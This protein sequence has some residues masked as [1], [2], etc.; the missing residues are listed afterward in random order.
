MQI[1]KKLK[2]AVS[3]SMLGVVI[4]VSACNEQ[5]K[6][7]HGEISMDTTAGQD[8]LIIDTTASVSYGTVG[9]APTHSPDLDTLTY[10]DKGVKPEEAFKEKNEK[11]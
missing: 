5:P 10:I 1:L 11:R 3:I 7:Q 2:Q 9:E 8:N 6:Q 4:S